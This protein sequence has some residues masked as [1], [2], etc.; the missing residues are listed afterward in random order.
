MKYNIFAMKICTNCKKSIPDE[1]WICPYCHHHVGSSI[2]STGHASLG[3][4]EDDPK[5][6]VS[7]EDRSMLKEASSIQDDGDDYDY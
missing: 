2:Q 3:K 1:D 6:S 4:L 7:K 5:F